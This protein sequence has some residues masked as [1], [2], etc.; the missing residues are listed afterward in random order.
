MVNCD[1]GEKMSYEILFWVVFVGFFF[2]VGYE[3]GRK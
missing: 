2:M 1:S 3:L